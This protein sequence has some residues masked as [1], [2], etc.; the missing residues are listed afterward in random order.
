MSNLSTPFLFQS[1]VQAITP[2]LFAALADALC[3]QAGLFNLALEGKMLVGAFA[4]RRQL[5][6]S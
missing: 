6:R 4:A 1:A 3:G 2:I 5:F